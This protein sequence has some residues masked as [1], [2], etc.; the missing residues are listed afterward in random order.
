MTT[1]RF[2]TL[3]RQLAAVA[4]VVAG[5]LLVLVLPWWGLLVGLAVGAVAFRRWDVARMRAH[6]RGAPRSTRPRTS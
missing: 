4:L 3:G 2:A 5:T 6:R 1:R